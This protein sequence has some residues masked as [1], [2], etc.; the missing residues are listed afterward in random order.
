M[1]MRVHWGNRRFSRASRR[2]HRLRVYSGDAFAR[3]FV[4]ALRGLPE[5]LHGLRCVL[6]DAV[7]DIVPQA[8]V[9]QRVGVTLC[10]G[11]LQ[12]NNIVGARLIERTAFRRRHGFAIEAHRFFVASWHDTARGVAAGKV[13]VARGL[14]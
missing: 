1:S 9:E 12:Q 13:E 2:T 5:K 6:G 4:A 10:G 7:P 11:Q 8:E 14:A 3:P